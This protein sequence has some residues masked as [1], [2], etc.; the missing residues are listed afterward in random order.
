M[1]AISKPLIH[2]TNTTNKVNG[3]SPTVPCESVMAFGPVSIPQ[4][5]NTPPK[6]EIHFT[7][8]STD[9]QQKH[10]VWRY[11]TEQLRDDDMADLYATISTPISG[12]ASS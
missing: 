7:I 2:S 3:V 6:W 5:S 8:L 9:N 4:F 11:A 10:I 1:S 12:G